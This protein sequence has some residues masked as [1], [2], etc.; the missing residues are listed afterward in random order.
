M[1]TT[2]II[3]YNQADSDFFKDILKLMKIKTRVMG[4]NSDIKSVMS[5]W[6]S[7]AQNSRS[8]REFVQAFVC[9]YE[10]DQL[11]G[12]KALKKVHYN[13]NIA[14]SIMSVNFPNFQPLLN[15]SKPH[16]WKDAMNAM[17][18]YMLANSVYDVYWMQPDRPAIQ[19]QWRTGRDIMRYCS[20]WYDEERS[21]YKWH[22]YIEEVVEPNTRTQRDVM[23]S[24]PMNLKTYDF[25][26]VIR[27]FTLKNQYRPDWDKV[28]HWW[29]ED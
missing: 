9:V 5:E 20:E 3:E 14:Y 27:R 1:Y 21:C 24:G 29:P 10:Q 11:I 6:K 28:K 12:F 19:K 17:A 4:E 2:R 15:W 23:F 22:R 25:P 8:S 18:K 13:D 26:V 16:P 7:L